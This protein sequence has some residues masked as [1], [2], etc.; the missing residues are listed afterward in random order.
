MMNKLLKWRSG[1]GLLAGTLVAG[2]A[3]LYSCSGYDLDEKT[4]S[5]WD[6]SIYSYIVDQGKY[7]NMVRLIDE[8]GYTDVLNRTGSKTM[9]MADDDAFETFYQ[10]N[11]NPETAT[12]YGVTSYDKLSYA[13][14]KLL[15]YSAMINNSYQINT[16]STS[17]PAISGED[18]VAG[19]AMRRTTAVTMY[20]T[21]AYVTPDQLPD[22]S[23]WSYERTNRPDGLYMVCDRTTAP[24][25]FFMEDYLTSHTITNED[26]NW[27]FSAK[28]VDRQTGD[29]SVNGAVVVNPNIR[30]LNGFVHQT[31]EVITPLDNMAQAIG[32]KSSLSTFSNLLERFSIP[33]ALSNSVRDEFNSLYGTSID[34]LFE[35]R[36]AATVSQGHSELKTDIN[37]DAIDMT[38]YGLKY[39]PSWNQ[40]YTGAGS[41]SS[42]WLMKNDFA[43][44]TVPNNDAIDAWWN[45]GGGKVLKDLYG[46]LDNVPTG[47]IRKLINVNMHESFSSSVPSKF[48]EMLNDAS[49]AFGLTTDHVVNKVLCCNGYIYETD[50]VYTPAAFKAVSFPTEIND[51]MK[52]IK[53]A[54]DQLKF[55]DYLNSMDTQY[56]FFIPTDEAITSYIDP[57][58]YGW[59]LATGGQREIMKFRW[60]GKK[61]TVAAS[62]W[63]VNADGTTDSISGRTPTSTMITNRLQ[64]ILD[65]HTIIGD[66]QDGHTWYRTKN[67]GIIRVDKS[68]GYGENSMVVYGTLQDSIGS[69]GVKVGKIYNYTAE[70]GNGHSYVLDDNVLMTT[71]K[72]VYDVLT[73]NENK[74][75]VSEFFDLINQSSLF[76][77]LYKLSSSS[78]NGYVICSKY[79]LSCLNFYNYTIYVPTNESLQKL[80]EGYTVNGVEV[81][82]PSWDDYDW[83]LEYSQKATNEDEEVEAAAIASDI[84]SAIERFIK[85]HVQ[86]NAVFIDGE[87]VSNKKYETQVVDQLASGEDE[88]GSSI[89]TISF[90]KLENITANSNSLTFTDPAGQSHHVEMANGFYNKPVREYKIDQTSSLTSSNIKSARLEASS[91]AVLHQI[92][93]PILTSYDQFVDVQKEM[94][95]FRAKHPNLPEESESSAARRAKRK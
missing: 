5:G 54:I 66:V 6:Q 95:A 56:S 13:Q 42:D 39:D 59:E 44:M 24:I 34:T 93:S 92:D 12:W 64:D 71:N 18:L 20:D 22:N 45:N 77:P 17:E 29:A 32:K 67:N 14:K 16:L 84:S 63:R 50:Q 55:D 47:V 79:N 4:P 90:V 35:K 58:S 15:L 73:A 10:N 21:V 46:T 2:V 75:T 78:K 57:V 23:F 53:W 38:T 81:K 85:S 30:C 87:E 82:M 65:A 26:Y 41:T 80:M 89:A 49:Q 3:G 43:V 91:F 68:K 31:D 60:D 69:A 74:E 83:F 88:E 27:L 33:Q 1:R 62:V 25:V 72:S 36:Y 76:S 48:S 11:A 51:N 28:N 40:Y 94:K 61:N 70:G 52:I 7:T 86:D 19:G 37:G 8:L 9:F